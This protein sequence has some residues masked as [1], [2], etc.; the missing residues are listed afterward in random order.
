M[1]GISSPPPS[2]P[3]PF[4]DDAEICFE[5]EEEML[6]SL[7]PLREETLQQ[8][9]LHGTHYAEFISLQQSEK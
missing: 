7:F 9:Y 1:R 8:A 3:P 6:L 4:A 2:L 5:I